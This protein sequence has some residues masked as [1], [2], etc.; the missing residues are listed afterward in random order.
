MVKLSD[1]LQ[2][3]VSFA[4]GRKMYVL[5]IG[6]NVSSQETR[7]TNT[8]ILQNPRFNPMHKKKAIF[9]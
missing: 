1:L 9:Y 6:K 5:V 7:V 4:R 3:V 2:N 8:S